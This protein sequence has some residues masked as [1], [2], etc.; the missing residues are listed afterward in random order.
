MLRGLLEK[1][2]HTWLGGYLK[3]AADRV[4]GRADHFVI[5]GQREKLRHVRGDS[6]RRIT[7]RAIQDGALDGTRRGISSCCAEF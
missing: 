3:H 7:G 1:N 4:P 5:R 6:Q 2:L